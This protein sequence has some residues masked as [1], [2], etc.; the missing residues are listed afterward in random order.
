[1]KVKHGWMWGAGMAVV[2]LFTAC[3]ERGAVEVEKLQEA[4]YELNQEALFRAAESDDL[5][6]MER[7][8][9]GGLAVDV[10]DGAGRTALHAAAGAGALKSID[11]L[12]DRGLEVDVT[13]AK[14][15]TPLMEAVLRSTPETVRYLLRQGADPLMKDEDQ[16]KPLMLAVKEGRESVVP[17]LAAYVREDLDDALLAASILGQ[18]RVIDAL[19]NFGASVY[20]RLEDGRSALMLAAQKGNDEA[21]EMLLS[22]GA[23]RFAMDGEGRMAVDHARIAGHEALAARLEE[24]PQEGDFELEEPAELGVAMV[25]RVEMAG[26]VGLDGETVAE[27]AMPWNR[28]VAGQGAGEFEALAGPAEAP[29]SLEG[30]ILAARPDETAEATVADDEAD[31]PAAPLVMRL[32]HQKEL[33]LRVETVTGERATLRLAGGESVEVVRGEGI[34]GTPLKLIRVERRMRAAKGD[35]GPETEVSVVEVGDGESGKHRELVA[36][37]PAYAHDPVALV[38]DAGSGKFFVARVGQRFRT[39]DGDDYLVADVR[40][41]QVVIENTTSRET[42]TIPLRGPRG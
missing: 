29:E 31:E 36:G 8:L 30:A 26:P 5:G 37:L 4:G 25:R 24:E 14:L 19:T 13:D 15:R 2:A 18:A 28:P 20:A 39:A 7:M 32:Y 16:F 33:P 42:L 41:N 22:I 10:K 1:M 40:P 34:P 3:R 17:E 6:A 21:V 12:L 9:A 11:F 35:S 27:E 23:N 38:E